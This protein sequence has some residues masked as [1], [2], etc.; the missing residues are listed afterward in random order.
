MYIYIYV[1]VCIPGCVRMVARVCMCVCVCVW[2]C[3]R[4]WLL[5]GACAHTHTHTHTQCT[6]RVIH[7]CHVRIAIRYLQHVSRWW[8]D[9]AMSDSVYVQFSG[10][11]DKLQRICR[12]LCPY[13]HAV[14]HLTCFTGS[15]GNGV[16]LGDCFVWSSK[17]VVVCDHVL[18]MNPAGVRGSTS[19]CDFGPVNILWD[20]NGHGCSDIPSHV[21]VRM[22]ETIDA[23]M[24][25]WSST[26]AHGI[27]PPDAELS[28]SGLPWF[29]SSR[30]RVVSE[31]R[32]H[33]E[34][35][36]RVDGLLSN[37]IVGHALSQPACLEQM[38]QHWDTACLVQ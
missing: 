10:I 30:W 20:V 11:L 7:P 31:A 15:P 33:K 16:G 3:A 13:A 5:I 38:G 26:K 29:T 17:M 19:P 27:M 21:F 32:D 34:T 2:V 14:A 25:A 24:H 36:D 22:L 35:I 12:D 4:V 28:S 1:Y 23:C 6:S 18:I 8:K 37:L 9:M